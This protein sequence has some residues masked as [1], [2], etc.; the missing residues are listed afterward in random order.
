M[1]GVWI[2]LAAMCSCRRPRKVR[3]PWTRQRLPGPGQS[4][5]CRS[6]TSATGVTSESPQSAFVGDR[7]ISERL[8][9]AAS[10][11]HDLRA[12]HLHAEGAVAVARWSPDAGGR[13]I[14]LQSLSGGMGRSIT[15]SK[16]RS[17]PS[18][19]LLE[20]LSVGTET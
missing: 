8:S 18:L 6:R 7:E 2:G 12:L 10:L 1:R 9:R 13:L 15:T 16:T 17:S 19:A 3:S 5:R 20:F 14:T 4:A 11:P